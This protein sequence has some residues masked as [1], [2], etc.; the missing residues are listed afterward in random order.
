MKIAATI[1][2]VIGVALYISSYQF[3]KRKTIVA[4]YSVANIMYV[5]QYLMLGAYTGVA[6]DFLALASSLVARKRSIP[7]IQKYRR[8]I[9]LLLDVC[10]V[11]VGLLLYQNVF[12]LFA[13]AAVIVETTALWNTDENK[14][15]WL[16]LIATPFWLTYNI[17]FSAYGSVVG[18][19]INLVSLT[20]AII[21]YRK[22]K[23]NESNS[24][25]YFL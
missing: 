21:R 10:M 20:T 1:I 11:T 22:P 5:I 25:D 14:I 12:S 24:Q 3:K 23:N 17:A 16:T 7:F 9:I 6:M 8:I 18:S 4:V 2:G 15:R 19:V 13:I